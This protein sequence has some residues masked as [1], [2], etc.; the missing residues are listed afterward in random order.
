MGI[1][2]FKPLVSLH[3]FAWDVYKH[4]AIAKKN[5]LNAH[6]VGVSITQIGAIIKEGLIEYEGGVHLRGLGYLNVWLSPKPY[7][8]RKNFFT[9]NL[10]LNDFIEGKMFCVN[11]APECVVNSKLKYWTYGYFTST[12][13]IEGITSKLKAGKIY[14][15]MYEVFKK[16]KTL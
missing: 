15:N 1:T 10:V 9:K 14:L 6:K 4:K 8:G 12:G 7:L 5:R 3:D 16:N 2:Y 11:L 13:I